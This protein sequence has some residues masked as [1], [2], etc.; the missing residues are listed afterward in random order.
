MLYCDGNPSTNQ[1]CN[2][3]NGQQ[4]SLNANR[5]V[6]S[7]DG[8]NIIMLG[9]TLVNDGV[10]GN[11]CIDEDVYATGQAPHLN[12]HDVNFEWQ[13][14]NWGN[15]LKLEPTPSSANKDNAII[16]NN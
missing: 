13:P 9:E 8:H 4:A 1:C 10:D 7:A 15:T 16:T 12:L 2:D 11:N 6:R 3:F 5:F 14:A